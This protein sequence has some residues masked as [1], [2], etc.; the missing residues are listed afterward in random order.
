[1]SIELRRDVAEIGVP[2]L[3]DAHLGLDRG[4]GRDR[5]RT[6]RLVRRRSEPTTAAA[7]LAYRAALDREEAASRDLQRL[8]VLAQ[9][10]QERLMRSEPGM[11]D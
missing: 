5:A 4:R 1:M 2:L 11:F 6:P 10:R 3:D 8:T 7:Y 9:P